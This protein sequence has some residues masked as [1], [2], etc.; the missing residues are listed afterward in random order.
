MSKPC[1][2]L[3]YGFVKKTCDKQVSNDM[4][5]EPFKSYHL[6][7]YGDATGGDEFIGFEYGVING[8]YDA[9]TYVYEGNLTFSGGTV[10]QHIKDLF[11]QVYPKRIPKCYALIQ[12]V[13][14]SHC[15]NGDIV[16]GYPILINKS[17]N[18]EAVVNED[19]NDDVTNKLYNQPNGSP[20]DEPSIMNLARGHNMQNLPSDYLFG[21]QIETLDSNDDPDDCEKLALKLSQPYT[22]NLQSKTVSTILGDIDISH[23]LQG[24]HQFLEELHKIDPRLTLAEYPILCITQQTC[25]C[26]T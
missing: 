15:T 4:P 13:Y 8:L 24:R 21:I 1:H 2:R 25:Y 23:I 16:Y 3:I 11:K 20:V 14:T 10:P 12:N 6:P 17:Q 9:F 22:C 26:C 19:N 18:S 7:M 5:V